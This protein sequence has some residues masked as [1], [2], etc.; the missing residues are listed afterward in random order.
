MSPTLPQ[1]S[2]T[3]PTVLVV[4]DNPGDARLVEYY[5]KED[6]A[7]PFRVL[8]A[9][10]LA[11]GLQAL[12]DTPVD[13]V[14]LDL[15]LPDSFG[16]DTLARLR[17]AH[18]LVPVAVLTGTDDQVLAL[19]ALRQGAQDYLVKGQGSGDL[20]RR[21][22]GY[23]MERSR[24]GQALRR[25][26]A[27]FRA[28]FENAG[29]GVTLTEPDGRFAEANPAFCTMLGYTEA[30]LRGLTVA[31]ISHPDDAPLISAIYQDMRD[32]RADS[33]DLTRRY[34][35]KSG[36]V[37][38]GRMTATAVRE[39][40]QMRYAVALIEDVTERKRLEEHMRLSATVFE[41]SGDGLFITDAYHHIVHVNPAFSEITGYTAQDVLG[42]TPQVLSSGRH[43][44][45]FYCQMRDELRD[46]SKWQGEIW[47]RRK[48]GEMFASWQTIAAVRNPLGQ[49]T[50]YVS[51]ISDITSRKQLEE[52]LSYQA[53]HD[54]LTRLPNRV[55]FHERLSRAVA[56]AH[57]TGNQVALMFLD[58]DHF[59]QVNDTLGH[60]AGDLLLQQVSERMVSCTRQGDTVARLAGDEFTIILEDLQDPRD[61][62]AVSNKILHLLSEPFDL[63][64]SPAKISSSI[65]IALY[66]TDAGDTDTLISLADGA[67]YRAK[68]M[69]RNCCQFHS[70][71]VNAQAFERLSMENALAQAVEQQQFILH[72]QPI[73]D[74]TTGRV[75]AAE[76]LL[77]WQHPDVGLVF[78]GQFLDLAVEAGLMPTIGRWVL[79]TACAD[80]ARWRQGQAADLAL[81]LN[82]TGTQLR[83]PQLLQD[84][85]Q[86][87]ETN[88]L[89]PSALVLEVQEQA[90]IEDGLALDRL[91]ARMAAL[92]VRLGIEEFGAGYSSFPF[93][94]RLSANVLKVAQD[95]V[96]NVTKSQDDMEIA[97][98]IVT[99]AH[100]LHMIVVVPGIETAEQWQ[101]LSALGCDRAQGFLLARPMPGPALTDYLAQKCRPAV[102]QVTA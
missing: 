77:R 11:Q 5:L 92:G 48:S 1:D 36:A 71:A 73:F 38:W 96:R 62:A 37:V 94:R 85:A 47:D 98:A 14:L 24:V 25:S 82:L 8:S 72:Y 93:L 26:E 64:G 87:L 60:L 29:V 2:I 59:K 91:F 78:P 27:R 17:A 19:A 68:H 102:F 81:H 4:E 57:R 32:G 18:P 42:H 74:V 49:I 39:G 95:F 70:E 9:A 67:M 7:T 41:N 90:V 83:D 16:L 33:H 51:V 30:E 46:N 69:G 15:S 44:D 40:G 45:E 75:V 31:S 99:V 21:A 43:G 84:I 52:R 50:H 56:R 34:L 80:L 10:T 35:T 53:N 101:A 23:A 79:S 55:L 65:G 66:P 3:L 28:V 13:M 54:P 97:S 58:L 22:V 6:P 100:G 76:A 88:H 63:G 86:A 20:V 89:P 61:A 12:S